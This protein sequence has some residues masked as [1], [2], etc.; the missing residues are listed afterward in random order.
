MAAVTSRE[1][2]LAPLRG[3]RADRPP[4]VPLCRLAALGFA[5]L[6][7]SDALFDPPRLADAYLAGQAEIGYDTIEARINAE[8]DLEALGGVLRTPEGHEATVE[9]GFVATP[10]DLA[11]LRPPDPERDGRLPVEQELIRLVRRRVGDRA[12]VVG[13]TYGPLRLAAG[14]CGVERLGRL[15]ADGD[16]FTHALLAFAAEVSARRGQAH[17]RS[18]A[19]IVMVSDPPSS[20]DFLTLEQYRAFAL[21]YHRQLAESIHAAGGAM[22]LHVCGDA[23]PVLPGLAEAG[24]DVL[25]LD[26]KVDLAHARA[27]VGERAVLMGNVDP[28]LVAAGPAEQIA[29]QARACIAAAGAAGRFFLSGGC[30]IGWGTP[31]AHLAALVAAAG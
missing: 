2:V 19:D 17:L 30:T 12:A 4:V 5:G 18:G 14:L 21:P 27:V 20:G 11:R 24:A 15:L 7:P 23:T 3:E 29:A 8:I 10:A 6:R 22:L 1:R 28:A 13:Y 9:P 31:K 25:S 26:T 16:G